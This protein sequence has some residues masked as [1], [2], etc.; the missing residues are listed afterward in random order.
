MSRAAATTLEL[1]AFRS[2]MRSLPRRWIPTVAVLAVA[3]LLVVAALRSGELAD[4]LGRAI[5]ADW[6]WVLVGV[7]LELGSFAGYVALMRAVVTRETPVDGWGPSYA[8]TVGGTAATRLLPTAGLG[9]VALTFAVMLRAGMRAAAVGERMAAFLILLYSVNVGTGVL[10]G[11]AI[12]S[13]LVRVD[14]G[15]AL[16][17]LGALLAATLAVLTLALLIAPGA[18]R[19]ALRA[20]PSRVARPLLRALPVAHLGARRAWSHLRRAD[21][22][23]LG[24][25]AWWGLDIAALAATFQAFGVAP[26]LPALVVAYFVG[27]VANFAPLPGAFTGGLIGAQIAFGADPAT[28]IL[29]VLAYRVIALWLPAALGVLAMGSLRSLLSSGGESVPASATRWARCP[30]PRQKAAARAG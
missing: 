28:A 13:G 17:A 2:G 4:A 6:R 9:G 15:A 26:A 23:L 12:T 25:A 3:V 24:A 16:A 20:L 19:S 11:G 14:G 18:V 27:G 29:A 1:P 30:G 7:L 10:L 22:A 5:A 21:P 8:I